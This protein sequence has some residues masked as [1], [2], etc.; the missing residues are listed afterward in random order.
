M[1]HIKLYENK[2]SY[3]VVNFLDI[4]T[5]EID[6][7]LFDNLESAEDYIIQYVNDE[8]EESIY[9]DVKND[10][11]ITDLDDAFDW[12]NDREYYQII[13][14]YE[15]VFITNFEL[16]YKIKKLRELRKNTKNYN[17]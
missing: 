6:S 4:S 16:D 7:V 1:K 11:L 5:Y 2:K 10:D 13:I 8:I 9:G 17:L 14:N 12:I 3:W 15:E